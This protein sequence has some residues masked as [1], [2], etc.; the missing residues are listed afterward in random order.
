[1]LYIIAVDMH[2]KAAV[3]RHSAAFDHMPLERHV[4]DVF[5]FDIGAALDLDD[6][7]AAVAWRDLP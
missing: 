3:D 2:Q 7:P 5:V 4:G 1:M 6:I